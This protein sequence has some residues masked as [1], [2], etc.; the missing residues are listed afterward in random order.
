[1]EL[2]TMPKEH[3]DAFY[4]ALEAGFDLSERRDYCDALRMLDYPEY[5]VMEIHTEVGQVGF[6]TLWS[7]GG[8]TF[9]E[10]FVILEQ[11]RNHGYG[12]DVLDILKSKF[13]RIVLE[14]E[15][16]T[17]DIRRRR[18]AFYRRSGFF[19]NN[20]PY[21]QPS[22]RKG[23]SGV[24]LIIMSYPEVLSDFDRAVT[25]IYSTV[26]GLDSNTAPV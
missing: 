15:P 2:K 19:E 20:K 25:K 12:R 22:Y 7:L 8:F 24:P 16:P 10:H 3:F 1:M 18:L 17:E 6:I 13:E 26:Y 23:E 5:S 21:L 9:I 4:A 11:Y 14:A